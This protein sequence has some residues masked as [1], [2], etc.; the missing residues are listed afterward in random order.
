MSVYRFSEKRKIEVIRNK[1]LNFMRVYKKAYVSELPS[2]PIM[3]RDK[4]LS[5]LEKDGLIGFHRP[6][7]NYLL[8]YLK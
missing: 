6:Q 8:I 7:S 3:L 2:F 5:D 1:I 4:A